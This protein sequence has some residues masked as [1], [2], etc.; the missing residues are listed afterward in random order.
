MF[1]SPTP[2]SRCIDSGYLKNTEASSMKIP[3]SGLK[4]RTPPAKSARIPSDTSR[5]SR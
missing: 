4:G 3:T 5:G 1:S 2:P